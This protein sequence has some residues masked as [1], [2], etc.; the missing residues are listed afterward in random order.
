MENTSNLIN[1]TQGRFNI[2]LIC[3]L[4][5]SNRICHWTYKRIYTEGTI[6]EDEFFKEE[7]YS[8]LF[9]IRMLPPDFYR[10]FLLQ[11]L[12][13]IPEYQLSHNNNWCPK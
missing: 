5:L 4:V 9:Y 10:K 8:E 13:T 7:Y 6:S 2:R 1:I 12:K 3:V 11:T